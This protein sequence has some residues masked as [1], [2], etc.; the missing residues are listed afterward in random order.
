MNRLQRI[1]RRLLDRWRAVKR[2]PGIVAGVVGGLVVLGG[3]IAVGTYGLPDWEVLDDVQR[4]IGKPTVSELR[5]MVRRD[6]Q[7]ADA[8]RAL[9]HAL[10][11]T[12]K[13]AR[14]I[15]AYERALVI[16]REAVDEQMVAN[17]LASF[18][19]PEQG[20]AASLL[21]R[22]KL[23]EAENGLRERVKNRSYR[24]R[25][26]A[27]QTLEKLGKATRQDFVAAWMLDLDSPDCD[28]RRA[29]VENLG[30]EGDR[31]ALAAIRSANRKD[32]ET[33]PWYAFSCLG[34]RPEEAEKRILAHK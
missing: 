25:W 34:D 6:P 9:G 12:G 24:V 3:A 1:R 16:D 8:H 28:V 2:R 4:A 33:T 27:L 14:A 21:T 31:R 7:D 15:D 29:A 17:L 19:N 5:E 18:G 26:G 13:R 32:E 22:L 23:V 20:E 11:E 10:Y 30:K